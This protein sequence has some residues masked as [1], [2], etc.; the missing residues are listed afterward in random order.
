MGFG[1]A[2]AYMSQGGGGMAYGSV[3]AAIFD[4]YVFVVAGREDEILEKNWRMPIASTRDNASPK[5]FPSKMPRQ[6][7]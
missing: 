3:L 1:R 2:T 4:V 7:M 6:A 5:F